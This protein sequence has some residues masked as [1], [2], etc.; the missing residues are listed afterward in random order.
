MSFA[1]GEET[2]TNHAAIYL[3]PLRSGPIHYVLVKEAEIVQKGSSVLNNW[4]SL[5]LQKQTKNVWFFCAVIVV[6]NLLLPAE[7]ACMKIYFHSRHRWIYPNDSRKALAKLN[8]QLFMTLS[9]S[10]TQCILMS[11][12]PFANQVY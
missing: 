2:M 12:E 5:V 1:H 7:P 8:L 9:S 10:P 3:N 6:Y 11:L 4:F